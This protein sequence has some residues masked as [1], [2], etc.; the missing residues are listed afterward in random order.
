MAKKHRHIEKTDQNTSQ[1]DC[2]KYLISSKKKNA[3]AIVA[4]FSPY[5]YGNDETGA[6]SIKENSKS[7]PFVIK[8]VLE[9]NWKRFC[10]T[11]IREIST[12]KP[13]P[14]DE[15]NPSYKRRNYFHQYNEVK[16]NLYTNSFITCAGNFARA[17]FTV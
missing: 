6:Y 3:W 12:Q 1:T 16:E 13:D 14:E 2:R 7:S 17:S 11:A 5:R 15:K 4:C 10:D 8:S 9:P